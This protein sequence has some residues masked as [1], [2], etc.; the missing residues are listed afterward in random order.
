MPLYTYSSKDRSM[1]VTRFFP[2]GTNPR[3]V[4]HKGRTL[5]H[6]IAGDQRGHRATPGN[7]PKLSVALGVDPT[8]CLEA[9][10]QAAELGIPTD[11][12]RES[13]DAVIR[14]EKHLRKLAKALGFRSK[15][16]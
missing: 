13:G 7:W 12:D 5:Y 2:I 14:S 1:S 11:F 10:K 6:D 9:E 4:R 8:Q 15:N 3:K 16:E